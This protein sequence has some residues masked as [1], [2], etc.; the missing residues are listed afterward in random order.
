MPIKGGVSGFFTIDQGYGMYENSSLDG[1]ASNKDSG[2]KFSSTAMRR[3]I[4]KRFVMGVVIL[5]SV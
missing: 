4:E 3:T 1:F 5:V 2:Y